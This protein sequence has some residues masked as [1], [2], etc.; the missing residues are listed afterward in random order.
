MT[1]RP[2]TC[3]KVMTTNSFFRALWPFSWD[4]AHI[5]G[6]PRAIYND[7][8]TRYMFEI[9]DHKLVFSC[10][11]AVFMSYCPQFWDFRAIYNDPRPDKCLR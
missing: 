7:S 9:Y 3:L 2:D 1:V 4:I 5:F 6:I 11:T 10:F 8:K